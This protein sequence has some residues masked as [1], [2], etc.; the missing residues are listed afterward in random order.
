[1]II[2]GFSALVLLLTRGADRAARVLRAVARRVPLLDEV[3]VDAVVRR[4][5]SRL[6]DLLS[7]P[8]LVLRAVWWATVNW[9]CDAASLYVFVAAFTGGRPPV[10]GVLVSYCLANVLSAIPI[11]PGVLGVVEAVLTST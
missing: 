2:G 8:V 3:K 11:T 10:V 7:D 9:L 6:R 5:A 1:V 4:L